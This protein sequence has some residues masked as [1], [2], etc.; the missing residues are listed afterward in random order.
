MPGITEFS[1]DVI[2]NL[3]GE[4]DA[5]GSRLTDNDQPGET[6]VLGN[7]RHNVRYSRRRRFRLIRELADGFSLLGNDSIESGNGILL[8]LNLFLKINDGL[9]I[10]DCLLAQILSERLHGDRTK[11]C[12]PRL[13]LLMQVFKKSH[14]PAPSARACV[15]QRGRCL[16][17]WVES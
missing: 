5:A 14:S 16:F 17:R 7:N 3:T 10:I 4:C 13:V 12:K 15:M 2:T 6:V 1:A 8:T 11:P 9:T